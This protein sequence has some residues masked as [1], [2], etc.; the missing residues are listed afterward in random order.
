MG[1]RVKNIMSLLY[2]QVGN[3]RYWRVLRLN[4]VKPRGGSAFLHSKVSASSIG[5]LRNDNGE[6]VNLNR[7]KRAGLLNLLYD[8]IFTI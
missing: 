2:E 7:S 1:N 6:L 4:G 8:F 3:L 5:L